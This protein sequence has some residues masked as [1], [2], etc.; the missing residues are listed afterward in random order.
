MKRI[1]VTPGE[2]EAE[3]K[4]DEAFENL[5][6]SKLANIGSMPIDEKD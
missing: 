3:Y 4:I 2:T 5:G 1:A 6:A